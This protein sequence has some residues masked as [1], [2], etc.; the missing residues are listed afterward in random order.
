VINLFGKCSR[1]AELVRDE[2][3]SATHDRGL[4]I[5]ELVLPRES[6][7]SDD[8]YD[9][10]HRNIQFVNYLCETALFLPEEIVPEAMWSYQVDYYLG[11][12]NNGGH[13]QYVGNS[14]MLASIIEPTKRGLAAMGAIDY[15]A[16]YADLHT[17]LASNRDLAER[18]AAGGGF[19]EIDPAIKELDRRFFAIDGTDRLIAQNRAF[20]LGLKNLRLV[21]SSAWKRELE[22]LGRLN[23]KREERALAARRRVEEIAAKDPRMILAKE[24]CVRAGRVFVKWTGVNPGCQL[25][26]K[27]ADGWFMATDKG[28]AVAFFQTDGALLFKFERTVPD[29]LTRSAAQVIRY[30]TR[31]HRKLRA[32]FHFSKCKNLLAEVK[33]PRP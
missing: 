31:N 19:G 22:R 10:V 15:G 7:N 12:V 13:G 16:I 9:V 1:R 21:R 18:T 14:R 25:D 30:L 3:G 32:P 11:Q 29:L 33:L 26:G 5:K 24:L 23:A 6:A 27:R 8:P 2:P 4:I 28:A 20:L 17:I